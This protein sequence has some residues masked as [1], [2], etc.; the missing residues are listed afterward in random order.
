M[1]AMPT[2][3]QSLLAVFLVIAAG[4]VARRWFLP[5]EQVWKSTEKVT[6]Y[7]LIPALL[8]HSLASADLQSVPVLGVAAALLSAN[9]LMGAAL[10]LSRK[11]L[12]TCLLMD[13]PA[14]SS[15]FQ[16]VMRWNAFVALA[17]AGNL[18]GATGVTLASVA[19]AV[20]IPVLNVQ[21]VLVLRR[22]G[23]GAGGSMWQ[24]LATNPF[25]LGTLAGLAINLAG[26]PVPGAMA[27][28]IDILGRCALGLGLLLVGAGLQLGDL[29]RPS[30]ALLA[31]LLLRL[32][33]LPVIG[34]IAGLAL[35]LAEAPLG[36]VIVCLAVPAAS[37]SYILARQMGG[38]APLMAAMLTAQTLVC[39]A[40]L[41]LLFWLFRL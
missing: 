38:D 40:T 12:Q 1:T 5:D 23:S 3:F 18:Y 35:A 28:A 36:V 19:M 39:F 17:M 8:I 22:Y 27:S 16:G 2:M 24:G 20:L 41:P 30:R 14:F 15:L 21:S 37:A 7:I 4:A 6:Y 31:S 10:L 13:G 11:G 33:A 34:G 32:I 9:L 25:I 29:L 26:L